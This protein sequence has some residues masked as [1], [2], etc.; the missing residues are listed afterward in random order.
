MTTAF[1]GVKH[2]VL[3]PFFSNLFVFFFIRVHSYRENCSA[4]RF[5]PFLYNASMG[6]SL[7]LSPSVLEYTVAVRLFVKAFQTKLSN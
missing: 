7:T 3:T 4:L 2:S 6:L 1:P 5:F